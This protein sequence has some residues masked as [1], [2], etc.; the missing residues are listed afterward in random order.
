MPTTTREARLEE[1][2]RVEYQVMRNAQ[3]LGTTSQEWQL[4]SR[5]RQN[6]IAQLMK[7]L[8]EQLPDELKPYLNEPP[9]PPT[10]P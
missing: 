6:Y 3:R 8:G 1:E 7:E 10:I 5:N 9:K 4:L 2:I